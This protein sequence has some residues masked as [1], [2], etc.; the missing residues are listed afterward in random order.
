MCLHRLIV[1]RGCGKRRPCFIDR[2]IRDDTCL[3][4]LDRKLSDLPLHCFAKAF[5]CE[6]QLPT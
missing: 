6:Q 1:P 2:D 5:A 3:C 4:I